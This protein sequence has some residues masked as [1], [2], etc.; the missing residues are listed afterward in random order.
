[1]P[2]GRIV[3]VSAWQWSER[4]L[5]EARGRAR[6]AAERI[7]RRLA[8][9]GRRAGRYAYG[10]RPLREEVLRELRGGGNALLAVL[11]RNAYGSVV[12]NAA[13][14]L[15]VDVDLPD[16]SLARR[17]AGWLRR[18]AGGTAAAAP[19]TA[20][21]DAALAGLRAFVAARMNWGV[22]V[23]RTRGG[24]RYLATHA[25]FDPAGAET[26]AVF[27]ALGCDPRYAQLCRS[28]GSF[29][30]RLTPK[31][32]RCGVRAAAP[33]YPWPQAGDEARARR[34]EARYDGARAA[35]ATCALLSVVGSQSVHRDVEPVLRLH[36]ELTRAESGLP[37]A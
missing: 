7:A 26:R 21:L 3:R 34:W 13:G 22:R 12:L 37:L 11:T 32:W 28:Q 9:G 5:D 8:E 6:E 24:L 15:F 20:A 30:A 17:L 33:L 4:S 27:E 19:G 25:P 36:D 31:P 16:P 23:Y 35:Y 2:G 1:M 10:A 14:A 18:L 29:R